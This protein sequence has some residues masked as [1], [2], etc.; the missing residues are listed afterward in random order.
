MKLSGR[1]ALML[2]PYWGRIAKGVQ[3][4]LIIGLFGMVLPLLSKLLFDE[5]FPSRNFHLLHMLVVGIGVMTV[6]SAIM[7]TI[8]SY[9]VQVLNARISTSLSL[10]FINHVQHLET[11]FFDARPVGEIL[12]RTSDLQRSI[13]FVSGILGTVFVNGVYLVLVP[14]VLFAL[15][16]RLALLSFITLPVTTV[17]SLTVG[18]L[19]RLLSRRSMELSAESGAYQ[20]EM[21]SNVRVIKASAAEHEAYEKLRSKVHTAQTAQLR[22]AGAGA[23]LG[24]STTVIRAA[25]TVIYSWIAWTFV[26]NGD[27]TLGSFIAFSA[28][29]GYMTGPVGQFASLF[30]TLQQAAVSLE[31]F[32]EYADSKAEQ[33]PSL[34]MQPKGPELPRLRGEVEFDSVSFGYEPRI[35][36]LRR[37]SFRLE[38][39]TM[40]ALVGGSGTGKSSILKLLMRMYDPDEGV[41]RIDGNAVQS[42]PMAALR[43]QIGAVWQDGSFMRGTLRENLTLG[44]ADATEEQIRRAIEAAQLDS[45]VDGLP[46]G[47][48]SPVAEWGGSLSGGQRQRLAI[49]RALVRPRSILLLDEVTSQLDAPTETA[50]LQALRTEY[51]IGIT[52]LLVTHRLSTA[53]FADRV[54]FLA[55]DGIHGG[56]CG[57]DTFIE[58]DEPYRNFWESH[59]VGGAS[60]RNGLPTSG[61]PLVRPAIQH[62]DASAI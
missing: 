37:V 1:L 35:S 9:F 14:P 4:N 34:A 38:P 10:Q 54:L 12:S 48:D 32:F 58:T 62:R 20:I 47:L 51:R 26:L 56:R 5:V 29:L 49:A 53:R 33:D 3:L 15:N 42:M 57:H 36:V 61:R 50:L 25:G 46:D 18:R 13:G 45:F 16:W 17:V 22:V 55:M 2:R 39:G 6:T 8:R 21:L 11:R 60:D 27:M 7:S 41:I 30:T 23:V 28:Y 43:R 24:L 31:R 19:V 44:A 40:T 59:S 52:T